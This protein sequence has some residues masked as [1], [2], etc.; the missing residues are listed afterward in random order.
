MSTETQKT[1]REKAKRQL[2]SFLSECKIDEF[3]GKKVLEIG[4]K[5]GLFVDECRKA[6]LVPTGIEINAQHYER[7]CAEMP[8]LNLLIYDGGKFPLPDTSFDFVVS[9][10]VLEHVDSIENI[11]SECIR[12]LKP[13]GFMYHVCPNYFSFYEGHYN[14]IW[15]P[16][17][18]KPLGRL[19]LKL[20][21]RDLALYERLNLV[22]PRDITKALNAHNR[23][24]RIVSLGRAEFINSFNEQQIR[25]VKQRL[26]RRLLM[27]LLAL[28]FFKRC[29]LRLVARANLYYPIIVIAERF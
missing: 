29:T 19:Y 11:F 20:L 15:F 28:P 25:K 18:N 6:G 22:K 9:F 7:T 14:I 3:H 21:R 17:L 10:Q 16:F 8:H 13:G 2:G 1:L 23:E 5:N 12:I 4:F 24:V 26:I 27:I